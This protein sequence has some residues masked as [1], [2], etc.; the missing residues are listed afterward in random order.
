VTTF[1]SGI[2]NKR[3]KILQLGKISKRSLE[4]LKHIGISPFCLYKKKKKL[5]P[6]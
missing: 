2:L 5:S 6:S 3:G 4:K 1:L